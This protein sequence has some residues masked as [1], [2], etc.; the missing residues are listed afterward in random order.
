[1]MTDNFSAISS[2]LPLRRMPAVSIRR[3]LRSG[4]SNTVSI[5]SRVV[6]A[7]GDTMT[8]SSPSSRFNNDDFPTFGRPTIAN[9]NSLS[10]SASSVSI[11][12]NNSTTPS[13]NS[14][15][16]MPCSADTEYTS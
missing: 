1:M 12:G 7:T 5:A 11:R 3:N 2:V 16:P 8:R 15:I 4:V 13:S 10:A 6:P 14:P 9:R